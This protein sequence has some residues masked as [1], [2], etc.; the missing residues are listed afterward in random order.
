MLK[1]IAPHLLSSVALVVQQW[2]GRKQKAKAT[3]RADQGCRL[4]EKRS[5]DLLIRDWEFALFDVLCSR[6]R[7]ATLPG[8]I[9]EDDVEL[10]L[11]EQRVVEEVR[12][13]EVRTNEFR[14][15][16]VCPGALWLNSFEECEVQSK[17][18][19]ANCGCAKVDSE[20]R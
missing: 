17:R 3:F 8:W 13:D 14:E 11:R 10:T 20:N 6:N 9:T 18:G 4:P 7:Q 15:C 1:H 12:H 5:S 2:F 19:H 16:D